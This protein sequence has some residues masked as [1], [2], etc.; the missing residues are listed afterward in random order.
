MTL[1]K[2]RRNIKIPKDLSIVTWDDQEMNE[3]LGI[4]TVVQS[5]EKIGELAVNRIFEILENPQSSN[6]YKIIQLKTDLKIR[7]SCGSPKNN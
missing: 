1:N 4:T 2:K 3:L 6:D 7:T 5:I